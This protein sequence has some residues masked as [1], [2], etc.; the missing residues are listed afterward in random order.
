MTPKPGWIDTTVLSDPG[1]EDHVGKVVTYL[2]FLDQYIKAIANDCGA[3]YPRVYYCCHGRLSQYNREGPNRHVSP[4]QEESLCKF[5]KIVDNL[6]RS[7]RLS[8][9]ARSANEL[10]AQGHL[11][12]ETSPKVS[13]MWPIHFRRRH[14][15][16]FKKRQRTID[17]NR[18]KAHD[19]EDNDGWYCRLSRPTVCTVLMRQTSGMSTKPGL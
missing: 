2:K 14:S 10:L 4:A 8:L 9:V 19:V 11:R 12:E 3:S 1:T 7:P 18:Q 15:E 6:G 13:D 16:F 17:I 5:F